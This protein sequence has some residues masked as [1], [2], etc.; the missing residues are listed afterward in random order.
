[1]KRRRKPQINKK[2]YRLK[3]EESVKGKYGK[4]RYI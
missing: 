3:S 1:M 4:K 2:I